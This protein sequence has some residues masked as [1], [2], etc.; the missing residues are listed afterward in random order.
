MPSPYRAD[1][2]SPEMRARYGVGK[3]NWGTVAVII[4][5]ITLF[6]GAVAWAT[7]NLGR[8]T[9]QYRLLTWNVT[10]PT[11]V[12]VEFEVRN[13]TNEPALC[14]LRAQDENRFDVGY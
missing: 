8:E 12:S 14:V 5:V 9:A 11:S 3:R 10:S 2:L 6:F 13:P 4:I 7:T 1:Q